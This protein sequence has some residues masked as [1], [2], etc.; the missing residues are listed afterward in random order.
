MSSLLAK[1]RDTVAVHGLL[2]QGEQIV[3]GVSGGPDSLCL[4]HVLHHGF[5]VRIH[6]GHLDHG[7]RGG[8]SAADAR[9]V[10][11]LAQRWGLP[12][13]VE[14]R[15]VPA[16]ADEQGLAFEEAA[17]RVRYGFLARIAQ[18]VGATAIAVG[19]NADDQA[20]T[21]LMHVLRGSGLAGLRGML[22][23]TRLDDLRLLGPFMAP[24]LPSQAEE[25][26]PLVVIRPLLEVPRQEIEVFCREHGLEPRFD[27]SNLD[28][29]YFRNRLRHELL[30]TLATYS[31]SIRQR[32]CHMAS[33]VAA[34]YRLLSDVRDSAWR[35]VL[36]WDKT[37]PAVAPAAAGADVDDAADIAFDLEAWRA[38]PV[39]LQRATLRKAIFRLRRSLRDVSFVHVEDARRV[40]LEG[41]TGAQ[42]TLPDGLMLTLSYD[43]L[44]V[45]DAGVRGP[46]PAGPMVPRGLALPITLPGETRLPGTEWRLESHV[47]VDWD[48]AEVVENEDRWLAHVTADA[49]GFDVGDGC[50]DAV[51]R[52]RRPGDRFRPHGMAGH[53]LPLSAYMIN[54]KIPARWRDHVPLVVSAG[55]IVWVCGWQLAQQA[56]VRS[57]TRRVV[58]MALRRASAKRGGARDGME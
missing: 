24:S 29:T 9:F 6:V 52:T 54:R 23:R 56:L 17:R 27:R 51:L 18:C 13:T 43:L 47:L 7:A 37:A 15:D 12:A 22:P 19:H 21:V 5:D 53:T 3:V 58:R 20:E 57:D 14:R 45:H 8:E 48:L 42:A 39:S 2:H 35:R 16:I 10:A 4:L 40:A 11:D 1:V 25:G 26:G 38:L 44:R 33:V 36:R 46:A 49:L 32:L 30:P 28:R 50:A 55:E 41:E 34:D 31:P